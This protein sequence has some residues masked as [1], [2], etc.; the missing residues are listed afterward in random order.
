MN[1]DIQK[2]K[3]Y[4]NAQVYVNIPNRRRTNESGNAGYTLLINNLTGTLQIQ[5][6]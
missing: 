5:T 4:E 2:N 1:I 6:G 3:R